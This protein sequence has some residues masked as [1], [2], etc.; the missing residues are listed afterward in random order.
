MAVAVRRAPIYAAKLAMAY[1]RLE[2]QGSISADQMR[3][4][5]EVVEFATRCT[6]VLCDLQATTH[7]QTADLESKFL[8]WAR[9]H[10]GGSLRRMQQ[11]LSRYCGDSK[12]FNEIRINLER[13]D[14]I[15][16]RHEGKRRLV[17]LPD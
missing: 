3:A 8:E 7:K 1:A 9:K 2:D 12:V 14:Q 15:E 13:S 10:P 5:I 4:A 11:E 6:E 16:I 17:Y